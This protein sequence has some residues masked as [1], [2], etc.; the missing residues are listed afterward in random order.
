M[1]LAGKGI[2]SKK[3][4]KELEQEEIIEELEGETPPEDV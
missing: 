3:E 4:E 1:N 2:M